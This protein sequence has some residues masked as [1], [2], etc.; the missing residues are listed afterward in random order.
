MN[1]D[2][3]RILDANLNRLRESLRTVEEYAR[4]VLDDREAA[5]AAKSHRHQVRAIV[6]MLG[7]LGLLAA[8]DIVAD[9]G[10]DTRTPQEAQRGE[11]ADVVAAAFGRLSEA[12]RVVAEYA[13]LI[14]PR[15]ADAAEQVRYA[16][17]ELEQR[18][19]LR[20]AVVRRFRDVRLYVIITESLC[21]R[22]WLEVAEAVLA[23]GAACIQLREKS[24]R[25]AEL[26]AR[27]KRLH[28][29]CRRYS[30]LFVINDRADLARLAQAD[31]VHVGQDDLTVA[32]AR[33][34]GGANLLVGRST[35][36][37][38]QIEAAFGERPDYVAVG[39][40]FATTTK[41]QAHIAGIE[42][43]RQA[44]ARTEAPLV[45]IGGIT[46]ESAAECAKNGASCVCV[47]SAVIAADDPRNAAA[48]IVG[49]ITKVRSDAAADAVPAA[50]RP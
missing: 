36:T 25:D 35:H 19:I 1:P 48:E 30:A 20:G 10:R 22:P 32:Q 44:R 34:I 47:C 33:R 40:M 17:Y 26:L 12:A 41:P 46:A 39:P 29:L 38:E 7:G 43:L 5:A 2:V 28:E 23:G 31:G 27:A 8:R 11:P 37:V 16:G 50:N 4:F 6:D 13:K 21:K 49:R 18:V 24:M 9:V 14:D 42:M 45:A 15:A 3:M